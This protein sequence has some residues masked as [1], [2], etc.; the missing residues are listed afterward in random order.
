MMKSSE[1][2]S[3]VSARAGYANKPVR[4][5]SNTANFPGMTIS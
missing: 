3:A 5:N 1:S 4:L 2:L